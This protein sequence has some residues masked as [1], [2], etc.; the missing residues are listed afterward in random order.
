MVFLMSF[1][2]HLTHFLTVSV[3]NVEHVFV[4]W[5]RC[6]QRYITVTCYPTETILLLK[7]LLGYSAEQFR[8]LVNGGQV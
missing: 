1:L 4:D 5:V 7:L 2:N 8:K 3:A 6:K